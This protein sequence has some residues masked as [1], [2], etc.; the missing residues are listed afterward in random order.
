MRRTASILATAALALTGATAAP[1]AQAASYPETPF[2]VHEGSQFVDGNLIWYN[3]SVRVG[4][5][6]YSLSGCTTV[7]YKTMTS[8]GG[9]MDSESRTVCNGST[10]HGFTLDAN[11]AGGA[12]HVRITLFHAGIPTH[13]TC[14]R[15][16]C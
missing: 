9:V 3:R 4:G 13:V 2:R 1:A 8:Q 7:T 10:G 11:V 15:K 5:N 14:T 16:G 6:L 12:H